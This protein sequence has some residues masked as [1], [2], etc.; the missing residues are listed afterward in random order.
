MCCLSKPQWD[1]QWTWDKHPQ[2]GV[3]QRLLGHLSS[4]SCCAS[5][6]IQYKHLVRPIPNHLYREQ[7]RVQTPAGGN[8]W[9]VTQVSSS[10]KF[11]WRLIK[12]VLG[13]S[14]SSKKGFDQFELS[15]LYWHFHVP[16]RPEK[17]CKIYVSDIFGVLKFESSVISLLPCLLPQ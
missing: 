3:T 5:E 2:S 15:P 8:T 11:P 16:H 6:L 12:E 17:S 1:V 10:H 7:A 14:C 9:L 13:L 4:P